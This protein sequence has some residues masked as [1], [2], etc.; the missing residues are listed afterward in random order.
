[1]II[2][3]LSDTLDLSGLVLNEL[4]DLS[5]WSRLKSDN[6]SV[7]AVSNELNSDKKELNNYLRDYILNKYKQSTSSSK[8]SRTA[9]GYTLLR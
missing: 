6:L 3:V 2:K 8:L 9:S 1:M 5:K 4:F 7:D